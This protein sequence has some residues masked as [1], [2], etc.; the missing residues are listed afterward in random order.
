VAAAEL[1][2]NAANGRGFN[3]S[4]AARCDTIGCKRIFWLYLINADNSTF[5]RIQVALYDS[6]PATILRWSAHSYRADG[7]GIHTL[8]IE[9]DSFDLKSP[10]DHE[11]HAVPIDTSVATMLDAHQQTIRDEPALDT[12]SEATVRQ[13]CNRSA[14]LYIQQLINGPL[15]LTDRAPCAVSRLSSTTP[16]DSENAVS[17]RRPEA[18]DVEP[19]TS[20]RPCPTP[21]R[22]AN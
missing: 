22:H 16:A 13:A 8:P 18:R 20:S 10:A 11:Y 6:E 12:V 1:K 5:M 7:T 3:L 14:S 4:Y 9:A 21:R 19:R 2:I 15:W 17:R